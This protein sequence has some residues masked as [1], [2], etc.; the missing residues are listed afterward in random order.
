MS[1]E[2]AIKL[3]LFAVDSGV[4]ASAHLILM[5]SFY[6]ETIGELVV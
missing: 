4:A 3:P 6:L 5:T 1:L 2:K